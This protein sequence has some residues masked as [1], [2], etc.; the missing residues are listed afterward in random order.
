MAFILALFRN[1]TGQVLLSLSH[2]WPFL[3]ASI[4][5]AAALKSFV[6]PGKVSGLLARF[7][8]AGVFAATGLAVTTPLCSC[9]TTA[10]VLGMMASTMPWAPVVAFMVSSPLSSPEGMVYSA[11][12]FG[13]PFAIASFAAS[14]VLGLAGGGLAALLERRGLLDG[15]ARL[16]GAGAGMKARPAAPEPAAASCA[17]DSAR[18]Q[19]IADKSIA[20]AR[21]TW[22]VAKKLLPMF[23]GFAFLGYLINGLVPA[24]WIS[25]LFG[26]GHAYGVPLAATIGLPL[27]INSEASLPMARALMDSGMSQGAIMAFLIA[28]SGT[29]MGA[30]AGALT[31]AR[32]KVVGL[33]VAVLWVGA[34]LAGYG[35]DLLVAGGIA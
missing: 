7:R 34:M 8:G 6:D 30:I 15:Q 2:N 16:G 12:L 27:Y 23:L 13:W 20:A 26:S 9:G 29:S 5:I 22:E 11:G 14:I 33:V 35:F 24:S 31:I 4:L 21:E 18:T 28:G 3:V 1:A 25:A 19:T 17:C 10:V 32:W